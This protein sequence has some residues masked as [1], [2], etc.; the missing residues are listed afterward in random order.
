MNWYCTSD[1]K[2]I[3]W[4][5]DFQKGIDT[6]KVILGDSYDKK[7]VKVKKQQKADK[8]EPEVLG[9]ATVRAFSNGHIV[10]SQRTA[11]PR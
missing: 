1:H 10:R 3:L 11:W 7:I 5:E 4:Q 6:V 9:L 2:W 8:P